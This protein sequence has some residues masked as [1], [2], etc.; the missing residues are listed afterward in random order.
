MVA[1][2]GIFHSLTIHS[3]IGE[4]EKT[5]CAALDKG[6]AGRKVQGSPPMSRSIRS[7]YEWAF[8]CAALNNLGSVS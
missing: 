8:F 6:P 2:G 5:G 3:G 1:F 7:A 4:R